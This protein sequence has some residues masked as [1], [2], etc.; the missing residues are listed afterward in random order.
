MNTFSNTGLINKVITY[1]IRMLLSYI[2]AL[3][4]VYAFNVRKMKNHKETAK[5]FLQVI[6]IIPL[7]L[8]LWEVFLSL[9]EIGCEKHDKI[10]DS[11]EDKPPLTPPQADK[12]PLTPPQANDI[13]SQFII[14]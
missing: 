8:F 11:D 4:L 3:A 2:V 7:I 1:D 12:P 5:L 6:L 14:W 10:P 9:S 13:S